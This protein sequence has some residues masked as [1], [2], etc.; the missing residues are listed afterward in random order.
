MCHVVLLLGSAA[1]PVFRSRFIVDASLDAVRDF[2]FVDCDSAFSALAPPG[3]PATID[4]PMTR[5]ENGARLGFTL[6][7]ACCMPVRWLAVHR[8][9]HDHG[10]E[11]VMVSGPL[12][13]WVHTHKFVEE[14]PT[15]TAIEDTIEYDYG[16][17][18]QACVNFMLFNPLGLKA[19][20]VW[21]AFATRRALRKS[22]SSDYRK[23]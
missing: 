8:D 5:M 10:F 7:I 20:F 22:V 2:H 18:A 17:G 12:R 21:R 13:S 19:L 6:W 11:D 4:I 16:S 9:V 3:T 14:T 23:L 15:S 1:M